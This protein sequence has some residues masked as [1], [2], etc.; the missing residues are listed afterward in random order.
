MEKE[1]H[2]ASENMKLFF[3]KL[4]ALKENVKSTK[5]NHETLA[6]IYRGFYD[7]LD[8]IIKEKQ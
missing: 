6:D 3:E 4:L 5:E 8:E 7:S 1:T 2:Q